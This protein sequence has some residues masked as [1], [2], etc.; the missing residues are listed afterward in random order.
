MAI[1]LA[2]YLEGAGPLGAAL[3]VKALFCPPGRRSRATKLVR[4]VG[5]P[6]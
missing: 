1:Y 5:G 3:D 6:A 4:W 2:D